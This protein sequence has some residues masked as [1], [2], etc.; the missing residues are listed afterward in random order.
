MAGAVL[1]SRPCMGG[2][3]MHDSAITWCKQSGY[4]HVSSFSYYVTYRC[5]SV[6]FLFKTGA[7]IRVQLEATR[8]EPRG[9]SVTT[10]RIHHC[11]RLIL[12]CLMGSLCETTSVAC[13]TLCSFETM[14]WYI[15]SMQNSFGCA[16]MCFVQQ[17]LSVV[18]NAERP[19][20]RNVR[21]FGACTQTQR[22]HCQ[23]QVVDP[24][25]GSLPD[26]PDFW[27]SLYRA[28]PT[29][30]FPSRFMCRWLELVSTALKWSEQELRS[31]PRGKK[32]RIRHT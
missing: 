4:H 15:F 9:L 31:H 21:S 29:T 30:H 1:W 24:K 19:K 18:P 17:K 23:G 13:C 16:R 8:V 32:H 6:Y 26:F 11:D 12:T 3:H 2:A 7:L 22:F 28:L 10:T 14:S 27:S 20:S 5:F 25:S